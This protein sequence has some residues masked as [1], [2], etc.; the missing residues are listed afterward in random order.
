MVDLLSM[1]RRSERHAGLSMAALLDSF[2]RLA[3]AAG[4]LLKQREEARGALEAVRRSANANARRVGAIPSSGRVENAV[5][6][7]LLAGKAPDDLE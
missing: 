5:T 4:A 7:A 6:S 1:Y 3:E 2:A